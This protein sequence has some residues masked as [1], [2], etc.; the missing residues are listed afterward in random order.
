VQ[1]IGVAPINV[2]VMSIELR[3]QEGKAIYSLK[4]ECCN[5]TYLHKNKVTSGID[6]MISSNKVI[7]VKKTQ[8]YLNP[9]K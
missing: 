6:L 2:E 5:S 3:E 1:E 8:R 9:Q 4:L 7:K